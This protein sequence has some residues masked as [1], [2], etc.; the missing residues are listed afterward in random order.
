M[1]HCAVVIG[2]VNLA[3]RCGVNRGQVRRHLP[4]WIPHPPFYDAYRSRGRQSLVN[5]LRVQHE[6]HQGREAG[7]GTGLSQPI[8]LVNPAVSNASASPGNPSTQSE[9]K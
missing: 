6:E 1:H 8:T 3:E 2:Q 7:A 4:V 5:E 9:A